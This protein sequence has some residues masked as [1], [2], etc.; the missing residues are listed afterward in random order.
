ML[1]TIWK[2]VLYSPLYNLLIL[3]II[4]LGGNA[5]LA[6]VALTIVV[7]VILLPF[8]AKTIKS[9]LAMKAIEPKL[10][11]IREEHA[12]DKQL[13]SKKTFELYKEHK[14]NPFTGCFLLLIQLPI[15]I[16]L[17]QVVLGGFEPRPE[18]LYAGI[19]FPE[20]LS[21]MF[22]GFDIT[23]K[24]IFLA[25]FVAGLQFLQ[26]WF[27]AKN[28]APTKNAS[29]KDLPLQAMMQ[30]QMKYVLPLMVGFISY[31]L[32]AAIGI[33]WA[34]NI[35]VTIVQEYYIRNRYKKVYERS[36]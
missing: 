29:G 21:T 34:V 17:Y 8:T 25:V 6:I 5:G 12:T 19:N 36:N 3:L 24:N 1:N 22:L 18:L 4:L 9:Q 14:V 13:Q 11:K 30:T 16:A 15:I 10:Q 33:Y 32:P 31:T 23:Q 26:A 35:I 20:N 27:A 2:T 7:K 28:L